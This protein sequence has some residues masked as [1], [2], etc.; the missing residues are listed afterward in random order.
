MRYDFLAVRYKLMQSYIYPAG[1]PV[2][3]LFE[4][5]KFVF[6]GNGEC[7]TIRYRCIFL[8]I[9]EPGKSLVHFVFGD[10]EISGITAGDLCRDK[11]FESNV[12]LGFSG[13]GFVSLS[14]VNCSIGLL[15][16]PFL[17][18][19]VIGGNRITR[20]FVGWLGS[21]QEFGPPHG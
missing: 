9:T 19:R 12:F 14:L 20:F 15:Q 13:G 17:F 11:F 1:Y 2:Y 4:K 3:R 5:G 7:L 6:K 10:Y 8:F 18:I 21:W 16:N